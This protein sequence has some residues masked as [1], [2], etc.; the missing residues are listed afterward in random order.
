[1][2]GVV[3]GDDGHVRRLAEAAAWRARLSDS[4]QDSSSA[5]ETWL[6]QDPA[7][8]TAWR[9]IERPLVLFADNATSPRLIAARRDALAR[10][11]RRA[12]PRQLAFARVAACFAMI[13]LS[14]L[15]YAGAAWWQARP[16][17]YQTAHGERRMVLLADGSRLSLDA[18]T[19]VR[20]RIEEDARK[21]ELLR[22]QARF[23]VAH[24]AARAF[25][26][27]VGDRVVVATGTAF[28]IDMLGPKVV[29][30]LVEGGVEVVPNRAVAM[31]SAPSAPKV[32][33]MKAGQQLALLPQRV[34]VLKESDVAEATA[35]TAGQLIFSD[36][37]LASVA[38]RVGR[39]SKHALRVAPDA[40]RLRVSGVFQSDD[41]DGFIQSITAYLP[42]RATKLPDGSVELEHM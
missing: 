19:E 1:M 32:V 9:Q 11:H 23:D 30:T 7:N 27:R 20:V 10:A 17:V 2:R 21:L 6:A 34:P 31:P 40:A 29:I 5:F 36:E 26:V 38:L 22:G 33:T 35:W 12:Q 39:Y 14:A 28:N 8:E 24:D 3:P 41:V 25:S 42:V 37:P 16:D 18:E 15:F 4:G 13:A